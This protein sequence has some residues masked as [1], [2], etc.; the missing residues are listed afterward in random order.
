M[1][2]VGQMHRHVIPAETSSP[3]TAGAN[4]SLSADRSSAHLGRVGVGEIADLVL[5]QE[6]SGGV[7]RVIGDDCGRGRD[8][9]FL[10]LRGK[11]VFVFA[12]AARRLPAMEFGSSPD[13]DLL[14]GLSVTGGDCRQ[15][16]EHLGSC[17]V[18]GTGC[19]QLIEP[20]RELGLDRSRTREPPDDCLGQPVIGHL[21]PP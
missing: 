8:D 4:R 19:R 16:R 5:I 2:Q 1:P 9:G 13:R 12:A 15:T 6:P 11:Q 21:I 17:F 10:Q 14:Q 3:W 7:Q 20:V 18:E